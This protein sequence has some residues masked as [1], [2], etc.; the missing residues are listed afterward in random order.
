MCSP[1]KRCRPED[2]RR[3]QAF[4]ARIQPL[5]WGQQDIVNS[6]SVLFAA[7]EDLAEAELQYYY[8]KRGDRALLSGVSRF[9]AWLLGSIGLLLPLLAAT[10]SVYLK[11]FSQYGYSFL[12]AAASCLAANSLFGGTNGHIRFVSSQ[13]K[14]EQLITASRV[15]WCQYLSEPH[16]TQE[17][18]EKG[19]EIVL[20]YVTE[21]HAM[22]IDET[23]RWAD[24]MLVELEKYK[25]VLE[26]RADLR[27]EGNDRKT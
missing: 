15:R 24:G 18:I 27:I 20:S 14:I 11:G 26:A 13:L 22:T 12:A 6:M 5:N 19:F 10:E 3:L 9:T 2:P 25:K 16:T 23:G 4:K 7:V 17:E 8:R 21:L 1:L